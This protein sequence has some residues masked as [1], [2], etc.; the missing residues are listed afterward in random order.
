[1]PQPLAPWHMWGTTHTVE[2]P[3]IVQTL[4]LAR[5]NYGRPDTF[6]FLF[7]VSVAEAIGAGDVVGATF[8]VIVGIGRAA[9]TIDPFAIFSIA[10]PQAAN[11]VVYQTTVT[12]RNLA[13]GG[14]DTTT[15]VLPAQDIQCYARTSAGVGPYHVTIGAFFAPNVHIRPEWMLRHASPDEQFRGGENN[16]T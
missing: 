7:T 10:G 1:M 6:R 2:V 9:V 3:S 11:T 14:V 8:A 4:Q 12:Q 5:V 15:S 16:A 13:A